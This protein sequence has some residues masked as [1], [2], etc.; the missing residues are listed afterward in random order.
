MALSLYPLHNDGIQQVGFL[1]RLA[2]VR[3]L[4]VGE[5]RHE[6]ELSGG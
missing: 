5:G 6:N 4:L 2:L 1:Q 3:Q